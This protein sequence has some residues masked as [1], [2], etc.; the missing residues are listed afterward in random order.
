M[1]A[2]AVCLVLLA[3]AC[4]APPR[5][6]FTPPPPEQRVAA[7]MATW[8]EA[9]WRGDEAARVQAE[10]GGG[11]FALAYAATKIAASTVPGGAKA[12]EM[13][14]FVQ[15]LAAWRTETSAEETNELYVVLPT[16]ALGPPLVEAGLVEPVH[17]EDGLTVATLPWD[18]TEGRLREAEA[19][20]VERLRANAAWTCRPVEIAR[21]ILPSEPGLRYAATVSTHIFA[22]WLES[23]DAIWLVRTTCRTGP[24]LFIVAGYTD[25]DRR[26][27]DDRIL[28]ATLASSLTP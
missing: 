13:T 8:G 27:L 6:A 20:H 26:K 7:I 15:I 14:L 12:V 2:F 5:P 18:Q 28:L 17:G 10:D 19:R 9:L 1:R 4:H 22:D 21:T 25:H 23:V 3:T 16:G 24:G 11:R